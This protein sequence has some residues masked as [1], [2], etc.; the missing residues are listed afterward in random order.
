LLRAQASNPR[1]SST[2]L[3]EATAALARGDAALAE[4]RFRAVLSDDPDLEQA[5]LGRAA[6]L[7]ALGRTAEAAAAV[8]RAAERRLRRGADREAVS[9]LESANASLPP[10]AALLELLG[11]ARLRTRQFLSAEEAL[12]QAR[13]LGPAGPRLLVLLAAAEWENG[14]LDAAEETYRALLESAPTSAEAWFQLG[15]LYAW[16]GGYEEALDC[17]EHAARHGRQGPE[18][19]IERA[20][21][22]E[23]ATAGEGAAPDAAVVAHAYAAA[24]ATAPADHQVRYGWARALQRA[25]DSENAALQMA[26]FQRLYEEHQQRTRR[27]GLD[28]AQI[29]VARERLRAGEP[30]QALGALEGATPSVE[31]HHLGALAH[32]ALGDAAAARRELEAALR[33]APERSDL[34]ALL[35]QLRLAGDEP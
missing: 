19:D 23:G 33:L 29:D 17:F 1:L 14:R 25:G 22:L 9:L 31:T 24:A 15:R 21:A 16:R 13:A 5:L 12:D 32:L 20:R 35:S 27:A 2:T 28:Q 4:S 26:E 10:D 18:L 34:R 8:R 11:D 6:A 7:H 3:D 30:A